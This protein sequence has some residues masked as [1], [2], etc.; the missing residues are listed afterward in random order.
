MKLLPSGIM[1]QVRPGSFWWGRW[2]SNPRPRDYESPALTTELLP[3]NWVFFAG[4]L[5]C[6][7]FC[8]SL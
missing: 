7:S 8:P 4:R 2:G 5:P 1:P 6:P 3:L